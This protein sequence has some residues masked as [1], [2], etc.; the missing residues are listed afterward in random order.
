MEVCFITK[1][2]RRMKLD[3]RQQAQMVSVAAQ[4]PKDRQRWIEHCVRDF[5][6]LDQEPSVRAFGMDVHNAM[7][8]VLP[9]LHLVHLV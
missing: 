9:S 5:A 4:D 7:S 8:T 1:G 2:Q 6:K 3:E